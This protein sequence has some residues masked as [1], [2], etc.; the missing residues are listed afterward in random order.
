MRK[1]FLNTG[2]LLLILGVPAPLC[3]GLA[4]GTLSPR[5]WAIGL[6]V[7]FA[8]LLLLAIVGKLAAKKT[9]SP[10]VEPAIALNDEIRRRILREIWVTKAWIGVLSVLLPVGIVDGVVHHAWLPT[11]VGVGISLTLMYVAAQEI[12]RRRKSIDLNRQ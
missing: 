3:L 7:W 10:N 12:K 6:L 8:M 5:E 11:L 9:P 4:Y 1:R 2:A